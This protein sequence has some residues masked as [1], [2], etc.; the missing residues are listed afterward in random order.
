M[1]MEANLGNSDNIAYQYA[2]RKH[3]LLFDASPTD[4][5]GLFITDTFRMVEKPHRVLYHWSGPYQ[6]NLYLV[7]YLP[8]EK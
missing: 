7:E 2:L 6:P 4:S 3:E 5:I 8:G 1:Q